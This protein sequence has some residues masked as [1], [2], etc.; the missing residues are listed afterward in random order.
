[1]LPAKN[2]LNSPKSLSVLKKEGKKISSSE[3]ILVYKIKDGIFKLAI[4]VSKKVASRAVD[5]NRIKRLIAESLRSQQ[6]FNGELVIIVK[7]NIADFK[8]VKV[9]EKLNL[10]LKK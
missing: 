9:K 5:R 6:E 4:I 7:K 1:M 3:F 10:L 2:R 8:M